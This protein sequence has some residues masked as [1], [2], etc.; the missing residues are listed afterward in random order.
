MKEKVDLEELKRK[1]PEWLWKDF[2]GSSGGP[3]LRPRYICHY[4]GKFF[5]SHQ[6]GRPN[7]FCSTL[8]CNKFRVD[9]DINDI[10]SQL[11]GAINSNE[12]IYLHPRLYKIVKKAMKQSLIC[13]MENCR[14]GPMP[15]KPWE[16]GYKSAR[17]Y[18]GSKSCLKNNN[19]KLD[20][21]EGE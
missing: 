9:N 16:L 5:P 1:R 4:C 2:N 11:V 3:A 13:S 10:D 21:A 8:C 15:L 19:K 12:I 14:Q 7:K 20:Y 18:Y 17:I 6:E